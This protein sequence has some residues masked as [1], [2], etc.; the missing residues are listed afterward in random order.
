LRQLCRAVCLR[1]PVA[2][3]LVQE[4]PCLAA[5]PRDIARLPV[6][7]VSVLEVLVS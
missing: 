7:N 2:S 6:Q 5:D 1:G 3:V 4:H